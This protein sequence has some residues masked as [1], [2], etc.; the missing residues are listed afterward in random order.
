MTP[1][2]NGSILETA[3]R[4]RSGEISTLDLVREA[5]E[6]IELSQQWTE[7]GIVDALVRMNAAQNVAGVPAL[8]LPCGLST[9]SIPIPLQL[10]AAR[11]KDQLLVRLGHFFQSVTDWHLQRSPQV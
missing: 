11:G 3:G 5:Q 8:S 6:R 7:E 1:A 4:V 9:V 2:E 10:I